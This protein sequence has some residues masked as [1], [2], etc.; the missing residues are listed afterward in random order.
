VS[1][2]NSTLQERLEKCLN[3]KAIKNNTN[4][5]MDQIVSENA[6]F[7]PD[8][9]VAESKH[10]TQTY[11]EMER[12]ASDLAF[13]LSENF[14]VGEGDYVAMIL[15]KSIEIF[16]V[17]LGILKTG[18]A[19][20]P[21]SKDHPLEMLDYIFK[22]SKCRAVISQKIL[23]DKIERIESDIHKIYIDEVPTHTG[24]FPSRSKNLSP[25]YIIYTSGSTGN[26]KG[27][28][29]SNQAFAKHIISHNESVSRMLDG[30]IIL[31]SSLCFD[32][33]L[34]VIFTALLNSGTIFTVLNKDVNSNNVTK[35]IMSHDINTIFST[36]SFLMQLFSDWKENP[37]LLENNKL[38]AIECGGETM[39][40][41]MKKI[42]DELPLDHVILINAYGPTEITIA[43][44]RFVVPEEIEA[45]GNSLPIGF[46]HP[47]R[48]SKVLNK[49]NNQV[50]FG[51]KGEL[52]LS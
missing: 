35:A 4:M 20:I 49:N 30:K 50:G 38:R 12:R 33:S 52:F 8:K 13:Y 31:L 51:E 2:T 21:L 42:K 24:S 6:N 23:K 47:G 18:A 46:I 39:S 16:S 26:S 37:H 9:I 3:G 41:R 15:E 7:H 11:A 27:V 29:I 28:I 5:N 17:Y 48:T 34:E 45:D 43:S 1:N 10:G 32:A 22:D 40:L 36:P 25:A 19:F 44:H 14:R